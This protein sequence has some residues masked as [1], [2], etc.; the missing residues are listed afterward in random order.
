MMSVSIYLSRQGGGG[1]GGGVCY[2]I[3]IKTGRCASLSRTGPFYH[4]NDV[5]VYILK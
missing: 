5:S 4:V 3:D 1:G 2:R